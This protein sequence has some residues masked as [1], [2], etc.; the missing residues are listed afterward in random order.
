M[1]PWREV[2]FGAD[3]PSALDTE[4]IAHAWRELARI[5]HPDKGGTHEQMAEVNRARDDALAEL[6]GP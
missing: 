1:R 2:L 3:A 4:D 6:R 5:H